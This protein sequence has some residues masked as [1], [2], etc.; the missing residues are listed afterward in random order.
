[1]Y[2]V[3]MYETDSPVS[4][5]GLAP[6]GQHSHKEATMYVDMYINYA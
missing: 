5:N 6:V 3:Y 2:L 1:M 4:I